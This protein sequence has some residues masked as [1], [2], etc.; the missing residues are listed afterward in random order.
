MSTPSIISAALIE[1]DNS[2]LVA[3]RKAAR[4]PFA[5]QWLLPMTPV[6]PSETAED[7]ARRH[8]REQFGVDVTRESFVDTVYLD[9]PDDQAKHVANV[10]RCELGAGPMRFRADGD[11]D[12]A[13]WLTASELPRLWMPPAL[14][15]AVVRIVTDP[16]FAPD[17]DW[18]AAAA[19]AGE[20]LPLAER[21]APE[22]PAPDNRAGW[23]KISR[24]YQEE[25][26]GDRFGDKLMWSWRASEDDLHVLDGV[27]HKRAL[28]LGSGGGQDVVALA[29]MGA[30]AV[31]IDA[32]AEQ[33]TYAKRHATKHS[34]DNAA[35]VEGEVEDLARFDDASFDLA[36]SIHA[37]DYVDDVDAALA[38]AARVLK[39]EG[40]LA[41]AVKH[42]YDVRIDGV[43]APPYRVWTSYWTRE[44]DE[45]WQ[46]KSAKANLRRYLRT[47]G[48][49]FDV[50]TNAGFAVERLIEPKEDDLPKAEGDVLDDRGMALMPFTLVIKAR[51]Q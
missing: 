51:K 9:D 28:V 1:R 12:D 45:E 48:E 17:T 4:P 3:H 22:A 42:P 23:N 29:K 39:P 33:L 32:S 49:W 25:R 35:F 16:E 21:A 20:A 47:M 38:E 30:L 14:R 24:A 27:R 18:G 11:Y 10:F 19:H 44:H 6:L 8:T 15:D 13:R 31:G 50:I 41:V 36:L 37:L 7:A 5:G 34:A 26:Y 43:G 46:F 2:V 40:T